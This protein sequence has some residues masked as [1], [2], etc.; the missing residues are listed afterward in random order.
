MILA[1]NKAKEREAFDCVRKALDLEDGV[2]EDI[3]SEANDLQKICDRI[4]KILF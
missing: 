3:V 4:Y 1:D 2:V